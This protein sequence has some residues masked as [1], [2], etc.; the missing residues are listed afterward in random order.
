M[1]NAHTTRVIKAQPEKIFAM[2]TD[3]NESH[4][5]TLLEYVFTDLEVD[6]GG[7]R[8]GTLVRTPM[9]APGA[10]HTPYHVPMARSVIFTGKFNL[11]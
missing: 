6:Q 9:A 1:I 7:I 4:P 2:L 10:T 8:A 11:G 3:C 5:A